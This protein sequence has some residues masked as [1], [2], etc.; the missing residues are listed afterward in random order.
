MVRCSILR[1]KFPAIFGAG[2]NSTAS[3]ILNGSPTKNFCN[4]FR[5]L[6]RIIF[7][8]VILL[9]LWLSIKTKRREAINS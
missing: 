6:M 9:T 5:I 2:I 1:V 3:H 7:L 8:I 4:N